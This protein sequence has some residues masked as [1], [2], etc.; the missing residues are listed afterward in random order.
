MMHT[1]FSRGLMTQRG[2]WYPPKVQD[3]T[4]VEA[5]GTCKVQRHAAKWRGKLPTIVRI[6]SARPIF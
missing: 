4:P 1:L 3:T 6:A 2:G 5:Y